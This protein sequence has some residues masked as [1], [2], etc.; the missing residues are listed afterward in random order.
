M[1]L[2]FL[3]LA[4]SA[5]SALAGDFSASLETRD[6]AKLQ[7]P[8]LKDVLTNDQLRTLLIAE[9]DVAEMAKG[10]VEDVVGTADPDLFPHSAEALDVTAAK[11]TLAGL[12]A[13]HNAVVRSLNEHG[14][15]IG[16]AL[17]KVLTFIGAGHVGRSGN[18][19]IVIGV[20]SLFHVK[21]AFAHVAGVSLDVPFE[22]RVIESPLATEAQL[23]K[24]CELWTVV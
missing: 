7:N 5:A 1:A 8:S 14:L 20:E 12:A 17:E 16:A 19:G 2:S 9:R 23:E 21:E 22:V 15:S 24:Q 4:A 6:S 3:L 10:V 13:Q 18:I 11:R